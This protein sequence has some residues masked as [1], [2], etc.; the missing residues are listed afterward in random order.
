MKG[1][2]ERSLA[3]TSEGNLDDA[4]EIYAADFVRHTVERGDLVGPDAIKD[5]AAQVRAAYPDIA[6][7][8]REMIVSQDTV[9]TRW[10]LSGTNTGAFEGVEPT[11]NYISF[12]GVFVS[13][14]A[15]GKL[16]EEWVYYDALGLWQQQGYTLVPSAEEAA[17]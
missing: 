4:Y 6:A 10:N 17:E 5:L 3:I 12:E 15:D 1:L 7:T 13:R 16:V 14:V 11:G 2:V 8:V 9:V